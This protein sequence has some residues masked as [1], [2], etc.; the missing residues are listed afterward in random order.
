MVRFM[1]GESCWVVGES[2]GS[3]AKINR[4]G[5]VGGRMCR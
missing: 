1:R 5:E 2:V 4:F 3:T